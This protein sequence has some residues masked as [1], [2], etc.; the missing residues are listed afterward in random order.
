ME[1]ARRSRLRLSRRRPPSGAGSP[2]PRL[3]SLR[4]GDVECARLWAELL[5][6]V[7]ADLNLD[8]KLPPLPAFPGQEPSSGPERAAS[9]EVFTVGSETFSWTPFPPAPAGGEGTGRSYRVFGGAGVRPGPPTG[10]W[11]GRTTP[12]PRGIPDAQEQPMVDHAQTLRS[13]PMCQ[14]DFDPGLVQLDIDSH[15]AQCLADSTEDMVW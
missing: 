8:G 12:E 5:R 1:A 3:G 6:T 9:L 13:C 4:D 10:S 2:S 11:Q 14:A 7:S 15:L